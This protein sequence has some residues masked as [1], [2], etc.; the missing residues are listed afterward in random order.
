[1]PSILT[2]LAIK[3]I[4][5]TV[6]ELFE[7]AKARFLGPRA[8]DKRLYF[9]VRGIDPNYS[10]PGIFAAASQE[11]KV[12]PDTQILNKLLANAESYMDAYR[13]HAKANVVKAVDAWL[14]EAAM[15]GVQTDVKTVLGGELADVWKKVTNDLSRMVNTEAQNVKNVGILEGIISSN[16]SSGIEDP[17]VYFVIVRDEHVCDECMRLHMMSDGKT[18]KVWYLSELGHGYHKKGQDNPKLG[19]LHPH[20]R[21]SL[22]TLMP[23]FGFNKEGFVSYIEPGWNEL[24]NQRSGAGNKTKKSESPLLN[25]SLKKNTQ[26]AQPLKQTQSENSKNL[27]VVHNLSPENLLHAHKVGG[28]IAPSIAVAHKDHPLNGFGDITLVGDHKLVSPESGT[29]LY[30]ADIYSP[31]Y[32]KVSYLINSKASNKFHKEFGDYFRRTGARNN[33]EDEIRDNGHQKAADH[34]SHLP[35]LGLAFLE[36]VKGQTV[37]PVMKNKELRN[38]WVNT[39]AMHEF[40]KQNGID[41][42]SQEKPGYDLALTQAAHKAIEQHNFDIGRVDPDL[43]HDLIND[44]RNRVTHSENGLLYPH[45]VSEVIRDYQNIGLKEVDRHAYA[46]AINDALA[47][48]ISEFRDWAHSTLNPLE[49]RPYIFNNGKKIPYNVENVLKHMTKK[50]KGGENFNYGL[51]SIRAAGANKIKSTEELRG[52]AH[53]IVP[54]EAFKLHKEKMDQRFSDL[55]EKLS[56]NHHR[57]MDALESALT[58]ALSKKGRNITANTVAQEMK[59]DGFNN[60]SP[61]VIQE[62]VQFGKDLVGMPTEYFEAK[63][64]RVVGLNEFKGAVVPH[65]TSPNVIETLKQAG[66]SNIQHYDK[67]KEGDRRAAIHSIANNNLFLSEKS[68][69]KK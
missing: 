21:C 11:E 58:A 69:S 17:V 24:E 59:M 49:G 51:G 8:V 26:A 19:G 22:V 37:Q 66:I 63:P 64:Q 65:G 29:P 23:G 20:C 30:D 68:W 6:D 12:K 31:R 13:S 34:P 56:A 16:A 38:S 28:L 54:P 18:P 35:A 40:F 48:H 4:Q 33:V 25:Y 42:A 53:K 67:N 2:T 3:A 36:K 41:P 32:P 27:M 44:E 39:P 10:L 47:P 5:K 62:V 60:V 7:R 14:Q 57:P 9:R 45:R 1:M 50:I 61:D 15:S 55:A 43:A 46:K 52:L